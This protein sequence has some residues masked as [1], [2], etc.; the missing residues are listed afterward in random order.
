LQEHKEGVLSCQAYIFVDIKQVKEHEE[1]TNEHVKSLS[2]EIERDGVLK[3]AIAVD[4]KTNVILDGHHRLCALLKLNCIKIP[5]VYLNYDDPSIK[6]LPWRKG[7]SVDKEIVRNAGLS[8][9]K[10]PPKTSNHVIEVENEIHHIEYLETIC[11]TP[12]KM[13]R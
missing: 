8:G 4:S 3:R 2:D 9:K 13:L 7:E 12:L 1:T 6:V 10:L 5:V 11:N